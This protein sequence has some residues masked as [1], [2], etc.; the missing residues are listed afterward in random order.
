MKKRI[1][2]LLLAALL[3]VSLLPAAALAE[4]V[5]IY[6]VDNWEDLLGCL[7][8][9]GESDVIVLQNDIIRTDEW[10]LFSEGGTLDLNGHTLY[11]D[12]SFGDPLIGLDTE[13]VKLTITDNSENGGGKIELA[14]ERDRIYIDHGSLTLA[15]GSII[16]E[17]RNIVWLNDDG[18]FTMTGGSIIGNGIGSREV[19]VD[20][21][22]EMDGDAFTMTGGTITGCKTGIMLNKGRFTMTG[23]S[24]TGNKTEGVHA[25]NDGSVFLEGSPV[26]EKNGNDNDPWA[27]T[28]LLLNNET[29]VAAVTGALSDNAK[30]GV[31]AAPGLFAGGEGYT[32]TDSDAEKFYSNRS[33]YSIRLNK[34]AAELY[35]PY[36]VTVSQNITNGTVTADRTTAAEGDTVTLTVTP[37][38]GYAL[39]SLTVKN[40]NS[41]V[42]V[43]NNQFTMPAG[44]VTVSAAFRELTEPAFDTHSLILSG[45]IGMNFY[46]F[47]PE[48]YQDGTMTFTV[49]TGDSA[50]TV[51]VEGEQKDD[52]RWVFTCPVNSIEMAEDI[53]AAFS[54]GE[55]QTVTRTASVQE[56]LEYIIGH[57]NDDAAFE[58]AEPL[59]KAIWNYGYYA[60]QSLRGGP[61]H[62]A[63]PGTYAGETDLDP[64]LDGCPVSADLALSGV[65]AAFYSLDLDSETAINIYLTT[66]TELTRDNVTVTAPEGTTFDYT[67]EQTRS[68]Y[69]VKITGIGAHELGSAFT[70]K[71]AGATITASALSYV[72]QAL[73]NNGLTQE[74]RNTAAALYAYYTAAVDCK[75]ALENSH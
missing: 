33:E 1:L 18:T 74:D 50:R 2:S 22:V 67:V 71:A 66:E 63:M 27:M 23:G 31:Y 61:D 4:D 14:G 26:I 28:D 40:G 10:Y 13:D 70:V 59:A 52:G 11:D 25:G 17:G 21:G 9:A 30:I 44:N 36:S 65:T 41:D 64:Q 12:E 34:G 29:A 32:L 16:G 38:A 42:T 6:S 55:N 15:G 35:K 3:C 51:R 47:L 49:G 69:R 62:A 48:A 8:P 75:A 20:I 57:R 54:Y 46:M 60:Q 37:A 24:V 39:D 43:T 58:L 7:Q 72:Q 19:E 53:T 45:R 5:D 68:G 73:G 56:Y